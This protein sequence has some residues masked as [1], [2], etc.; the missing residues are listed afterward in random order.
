MH[1][2]KCTTRKIHT[3][4]HPRLE[5]RIF[6]IL[7]SEDIEDF[8]DIKFVSQ[9]VLKF[10]RVSSKHPRVFLE[11]LR[12]SSAIFENFPK[13]SATFVWPSDKFWRIFGNLWKEVRNLRK[14]VKNAVIGMSI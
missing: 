5:W 14:I 12:Q 8:T 13:C 10:V 3:K 11:I 9:L 2:G 6:H 1:T 7:T 4:P